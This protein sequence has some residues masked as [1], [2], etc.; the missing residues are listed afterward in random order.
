[1]ETLRRR[2]LVTVS[3]FMLM[4]IFLFVPTMTGRAED[5]T[6]TE[7]TTPP[8]EWTEQ[9]TVNA[10]VLDVTQA[11][12][13]IDSKEDLY[14]LNAWI[15]NN[16]NTNLTINLNADIVV[17]DGVI[18]ADTDE[19]GVYL[20]IPINADCNITFNGNGHTI[21]GLYFNDKARSNAGFFGSC[22]GSVKVSKLG[23]VNSY[24][25]GGSNVG[26]FAGTLSSD[27]EIF[28]CYSQSIVSAEDNAVGGIVAVLNGSATIS[29][30]YN[31][32]NVPCAPTSYN[33][34]VKNSCYVTT[35][36]SELATYAGTGSAALTDAEFKSGAAAYVLSGG[37][38]TDELGGYDEDTAWG[39]KLTPATDGSGATTNKSY[40]VFSDDKVYF[41]KASCT[42]QETYINDVVVDFHTGV[43]KHAATGATCAANG[44][45][46]YY[47]CTDCNSIV[48]LNENGIFEVVEGKTAADYTIAATGHEGVANDTTGR[49]TKFLFNS[50]TTKTGDKISHVHVYHFICTECGEVVTDED[51]AAITDE[52]DASASVILT[53]KGAACLGI[54]T[55]Y[56]CADCGYEETVKSEATGEHTEVVYCTEGYH[57]TMCSACRTVT[58]AKAAHTIKITTEAKDATCE[59]DGCTEGSVCEVCGRVMKVS[60]VIDK[61]GHSWSDWTTTKEP[62][63]EEAGSRER[64]CYTCGK[65][66]TEEIAATGHDEYDVAQVDPTCTEKGTTAGVKCKVC[67]DTLYGCEEIPALGHREVVDEAVAPTCTTPGKTAGKHC[68]VCGE[69]TE[70]Q[71]VVEATGH[72]HTEVLPAVAPDCKTGTTG[73]TAGEKCTDCGTIIT[74]QEVVAAEHKPETL[75]PKDATCTEDGYSILVQCSVCGTEIRKVVIPATGH[76]M[77]DV[78]AVEAT[79]TTAGNIAHKKCSVC[80]ALQDAEG[81][82]LT[83]E[84]VVV[85]ATGHTMEDV[86][87][88]APTCTTAGNIAHKKCSVCGLLQDAEGNVLTA[89]DVVVEVIAHTMEDVEAVEATCTTAGNIAHKK[90]SVCGTLQDADGN[91]LTAEGI[92]VKATGH[93]WAYKAAVEATCTTAGNRDYLYCSVCKAFQDENDTPDNVVIAALGHAW[94]DVAALAPTCTTDGHIAYQHCPRC[95][96]DSLTED[97]R[98]IEAAHTNIVEDAAVEATCTTP[99]K[100]AGS[101][102]ADCGT[103]IEA[104]Q[105]TELAEH[106]WEDVA[107]KAATCTEAGNIAHKKCANCD[108]LQSTEGAELKAEDIVVKALGHSFVVD[109]ADMGWAYDETNGITSKVVIPCEHEGCTETV[110]KASVVVTF[111][112]GADGKSL[113]AT[114]KVTYLGKQTTKESTF[115][116]TEK[117]TQTNEGLNVEYTFEQVVEEGQEGISFTKTSTATGVVS[118]TSNTITYTAEITVNGVTFTTTRVFDM[119]NI[120]YS[121]SKAGDGYE[122]IAVINGKEE[123][124]GTLRLVI[125][126]TKTEERNDDGVLVKTIYT[127][128]VQVGDY[129]IATKIKEVAEDI[130]Y[131]V[132]V[133][134]GTLSDG[135]TSQKVSYGTLVTLTH[136]EITVGYFG[137]WYV[138]GVLVSQS[139]T[140]SFYV[141]KDVT[142]EART[143]T[144]ELEK[145]AVLTISA[146]DREAVEGTD[147]E[148]FAIV[149]T[150]EIP[151]GCTFVEAGYKRIITTDAENENKDIYKALTGTNTSSSYTVSTVKNSLTTKAGSCTAN[152]TLSAKTKTNNI[153][154]VA[155]VTYID[156]NGDSHT[157]YSEN[158]IASMA[159]K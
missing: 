123:N 8:T 100:T 62:T 42:G 78:E 128:K 27:S 38:D 56:Y 136:D 127:A 149:Y 129:V 63:C 29:S 83:A 50:K 92:V 25:H 22:E 79:C 64:L 39:Q 43:V 135:T 6:P 65:T 130:I 86:E 146:T 151:E 28:E 46:E 49:Y 68:S 126:S 99:G 106:A 76:T 137:G 104:Q 72:Q 14:G 141:K 31:T 82:A 33:A 30:C 112:K 36:A 122:L 154:A 139:D 89:E 132:T 55:T 90:C 41:G 101:H 156:A 152:L 16:S 157:V 158:L 119:N 3:L 87:A 96:A 91:E 102:C 134:G 155:Y 5:A 13:D 73:L 95:N 140:Y 37:L 103:V 66:E 60:Q 148:K 26:A 142:V 19:F 48:A 133:Q 74:P 107:E 159:T 118:E 98:K 88:V 4:V 45:E 59:E 150:W 120:N 40:P 10:T 153:Y 47:E 105:D 58:S 145:K 131:T 18:N 17:N 114:G 94:E 85:E 147:K 71:K 111:A 12:C 70:A 9:P 124:D 110:D 32:G 15:K 115:N 93:T 75:G 1:M 81:N 69:V 23:I 84:D 108:A 113:V 21:S 117:A 67:G 44:N 20:W 121:W 52:V 125:Q 144:A 77:E 11:S 34:N 54:T 35:G 143:S 53:Q 51:G 80:G 116:V 24:F 109:N 97:E 138:D 7:P 57:W 61:L 2:F